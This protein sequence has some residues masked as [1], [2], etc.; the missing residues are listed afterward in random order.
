VDNP[1]VR[2][3]PGLY[4][5]AILTFLVVLGVLWKYAWGPLLKALDERQKTIAAAVDD[6]RQA[7]EQLERAQQESAGVMAAARVE[8]EQLMARARVDA[9]RFRQELRDKAAAEAETITRNAE[10]EIQRETAKAVDQIRREAVDLS[11]AIASKLLRREVTAAD[12]DA[13]VREAVEEM[14]RTRH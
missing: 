7:R 4:I 11:V 12:Q 1:L 3:D 14:G 2:L 13:L 10:R 5:W 8:A 9:D 6:A